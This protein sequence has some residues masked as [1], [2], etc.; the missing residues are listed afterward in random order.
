MEES[1]AISI[2]L[3]D[4]VNTHE[5]NVTNFVEEVHEH[6]QRVFRLSQDDPIRR[7]HMYFEMIQP[8]DSECWWMEYM[9]PYA[10][11]IEVNGIEAVA[12][13][14]GR[15]KHL[16]TMLVFGI[17]SVEQT[18]DTVWEWMRL[19]GKKLIDE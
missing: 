3:G 13:I 15:R 4:G 7:H 6:I 16:G 8:C 14:D 2:E 18:I 17:H 9:H 10:I 11:M 19:K 1:V 12:K 5:D